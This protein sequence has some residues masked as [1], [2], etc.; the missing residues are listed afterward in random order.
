VRGQLRAAAASSTIASTV[1]LAA[2]TVSGFLTF[3][4]LTGLPSLTAEANPFAEWLIATAGWPAFAV[5]RLAVA[6]VALAI[7]HRKGAVWAAWVLGAVAG[8]DA[9]WDGVV[10]LLA[11]GFSVAT[12]AVV[13]YAAASLAGLAVAWVAVS[14]RARGRLRG[15]SIEGFMDWNALRGCSIVFALLLILSGVGPFVTLSPVQTVQASNG[16]YTYA[17]TND[18]NVLKLTDDGQTVIWNKSITPNKLH[19]LKVGK[20]AVYVGEAQDVQ[21]YKLSKDDG[22]VTWD[23]Y[24]DDGV[25]EQMA[26]GQSGNDLYI[27]SSDGIFRINTT[28][29]SPDWSMGG[30][31]SNDLETDSAGDIF[32]DSG[33]SLK[34]IAPNGTTLWSNSNVDPSAIGVTNEGVYIG[35][36]DG[37][38]T[39]LDKQGN[40]VWNSSVMTWNEIR[41][42]ETDS[43]GGVYVSSNDDGSNQNSEVVA[44][45]QNGDQIWRYGADADWVGSMAPD[46]HGNLYLAFYTNKM[47]SISTSD[48]SQQWIYSGFS[49]GVVGVGAQTTSNPSIF[50]TVTDSSG[51][52]IADAYVGVSNSSGTV[53]NGLTDGDGQYES[54]DLADGDYTVTSGKDG[55]AEES[56]TVT[57]SGSSVTADFSLK[58]T[59]SG[60]VISASG[61]G[62]TVA[63]ATVR[64][65]A[66]NYSELDV[67]PSEHESRA[68]ELIKQASNVTPPNWTRPENI[69]LRSEFRNVDG[70]YVAVHRQGDWDLR[71]YDLSRLDRTVGADPQL[72]QPTVQLDGDETAVFS[73]WDASASG[74]VQDNADEDL[75]GATTSGTVVIESVGAAGEQ[76]DTQRVE[77]SDTVRI[78]S[79]SN[80]TAKTHE[81]AAL[82]LPEGFYRVYPESNPGA[83]QTVVVG[84]PESI[85][86]GWQ[87]DLKTQ[88]GQL[89]ER[90]QDLREWRNQSKIEY[91]TATTDSNGRFEIPVESGRLDTASVIAYRTPEGMNTDDPRNVTMED[92]RV[93]YAT[94]DYNGSFVLPASPTRTDV[95]ASGVDVRVREVEA[96]A[97]ADLDRF[98]NVSEW[99]SNYLQNESFSDLPAPLQ[100]ALT[101]TTRAN[102]EKTYAELENLT[103]ANSE[104][105]ER[106]GELLKEK[107]GDENVTWNPDPGDLED[108]EL[109]QRID[110]LQQTITELRDTIEAGDSAREFGDE[111]VSTEQ[112]FSGSLDE[113][114]VT[115]MAHWTNGTS[116]LVPD[117]FVSVDRSAGT[118]VGAGTTTV[119]VDDY[120]LAADD[121]AGVEF[122][123]IVA[124]DAGVGRENQ[125]VENP[126]FDG[127]TPTLDALDLSTLAPGPSET[128]SVRAVPEEDSGFRRL[129]DVTVFAPDGAVLDTSNV[130]AGNR[131]NFSTAG[132]GRYTVRLGMESTDGTVFTETVRIRATETDIDRPASVRAASGPTGLFALVGESFNGG[133][134]DVSDNGQQLDVVAQI[135][136]D[137]TLPTQ[138]HLYTEGVQSAASA[139]TTLS[140]VRGEDRRSIDETVGVTVHSTRLSESALMYRNGN[141]LTADGETRHGSYSVRPEGTSVSTYTDETGRLELET[142][143]S[144]GWIDRLRFR[145]STLTADL[146]SLPFSTVAPTNLAAVAGVVF[147]ARRRRGG[148]P[149]TA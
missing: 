68:D 106:S 60:R 118:A 144:P 43:D 36:N 83:S 149:P 47:V 145:L 67:D 76:I 9:V 103:E 28:D 147:V 13:E 49:N 70:K 3:L 64:L 31:W 79:L 71:G 108:T 21:V 115:V 88:A 92:L 82:D 93:F 114:D 134:V 135:P 20:D 89:T 48:G 6:G 111:T 11:P 85:V 35:R 90:A 117:E 38:I 55:Y 119:S 140:V 74:L 128:V 66:V 101:N 53:W 57:I 54:P 142:H 41:K 95:P 32:A 65:M 12:T 99:L 23:W 69:D 42:I 15:L 4:L 40:F 33:S 22:S 96:P 75:P 113:S 130:S 78:R 125:R 102:L 123:Y 94:S 86:S 50:G 132:E 133:S 77:T 27:S 18:G 110:A 72:S 129:S 29:G 126:A 30:G 24:K 100:Q 98:S 91:L 127:E 131:F 10:Y 17:A 105:R 136:E 122:E 5:V 116:S 58:R 138:V 56:K 7:F 1:A 61:D 121:P 19:R 45:D 8:V 16:G 63:N 52:P 109:R 39:K 139:T 120:P 137:A 51:N 80:P 87:D 84:D 44:I 124:N 107:T 26:L 46:N 25:I 2:V 34:K 141:P 112:T 143:N 59:V 97:F 148:R 37:N 81:T 73:V 14:P 146:P 62:T 104:L